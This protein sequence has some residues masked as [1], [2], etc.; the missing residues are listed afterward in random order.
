MCSRADKGAWSAKA[1]NIDHK[2]DY[3]MERQRIL[4]CGGRIDVHRDEDGNAL[5]P[6][7]VWL[8][9][10]D[11]PGLAM[12]R[13]FGDKVGLQAGI[14]AEPGCSRVLNVRDIRLR[15]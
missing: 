14:I 1:L 10:I 7:R 2:P 6:E 5:G 8:K 9:H 11:A 4:K 3:V 13:S 12:T 15:A